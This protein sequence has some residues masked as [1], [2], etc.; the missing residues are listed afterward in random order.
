MYL[1]VSVN[2]SHLVIPM[3]KEAGVLVSLL[4]KAKVCKENGYGTTATFTITDD[5]IVIHLIDDKRVIQVP[6]NEHSAMKDL[7]K[8]TTRVYDA[9]TARDKLQKELDVL[10][11]K[12]A[13]FMEVKKEEKN[14]SLL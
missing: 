11:L 9:E 8:L 10:K 3:S 2:Y 6:S 12:F 7:S 1:V 5:P 4:E 14:E 13:P